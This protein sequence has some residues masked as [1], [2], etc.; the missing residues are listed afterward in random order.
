M[1]NQLFLHSRY[2]AALPWVSLGEAEVAVC[3]PPR[4]C[5]GQR[6]GNMSGDDEPAGL[7]TG[8]E[9]CE[10]LGAHKESCGRR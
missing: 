10:S 5:V 7:G 3:Y 8:G 4:A 2:F 1:A 9:G 6:L